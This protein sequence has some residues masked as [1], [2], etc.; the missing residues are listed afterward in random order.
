[1][2]ASGSPDRGTWLP[3]DEP[4]TGP[5]GG[6]A[7][8]ARARRDTP[9]MVCACDLPWIT[10]SSLT[11]LLDAVTNGAPAAAYRGP[12]GVPAWS[13]LA[14]APT[15]AGRAVAAFD[16]GERALRGTFADVALILE[17]ADLQTVT[18]VDRPE[19]LPPDLRCGP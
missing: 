15:A 4:G 8:A 19:D 18:D 3:D 13:V 2:I 6:V 16:Q 7:S 5:L 1:M 11:P 10:S 9:L 14:L 17:P 12:G